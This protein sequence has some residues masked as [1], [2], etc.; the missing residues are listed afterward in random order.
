MTTV[1]IKAIPNPKATSLRRFFSTTILREYSV[2]E[3]TISEV[4]SRIIA[5]AANQRLMSDRDN[6]KI[7]A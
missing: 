4:I 5:I 6:G 2:A 3:E 7:M 1:T